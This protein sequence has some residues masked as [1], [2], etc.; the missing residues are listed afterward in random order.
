MG[1]VV[2]PLPVSDI[3]LAA[4]L[5]KWDRIAKYGK[6]IRGK[7]NRI[8]GGRRKRTGEFI[9]YRNL[10]MKA[11]KEGPRVYVVRSPV[12]YRQLCLTLNCVQ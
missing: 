10:F 6:G 11:R 1:A 12:N 3:F 9:K 8:W 2:S 5:C 7:E 4:G